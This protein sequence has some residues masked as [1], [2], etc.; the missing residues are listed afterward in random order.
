MTVC[1]SGNKN[2][3][4][5]WAREGTCYVICM[6]CLIQIQYKMP[7][8]VALKQ[9]TVCVA[10]MSFVKN[11]RSEGV[12]LLKLLRGIVKFLFAADGSWCIVRV[13]KFSSFHQQFAR[14][15]AKDCVIGW[16]KLRLVQALSDSA[17]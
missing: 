14:F 16:Y 15:Y 5:Y 10:S 12:W 13:T 9:C 3:G 1:W 4:F 7:I 6:I 2:G 8:W 17:K 11:S